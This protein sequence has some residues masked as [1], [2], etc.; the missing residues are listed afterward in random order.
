MNKPPL[1][2]A[3]LHH[4]CLDTS[5]INT[6]IPWYE[7]HL[8]IDSKKLSDGSVWLSGR[9]RNI[10][11]RPAAEKGL[12]Y[13]AYALAD[14]EQLSRFDADMTAKAVLRS[15]VHSPVFADGQFAII[16]PDGKCFVFGLPLRSKTDTP[17][18]LPGRLQHIG[19]CSTDINRL[20]NFFTNTVGF[21]ASDIVKNDDGKVS[22]CFLRSD[23]EHHDLARA[24]RL[25]LR[26]GA[27]VGGHGG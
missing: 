24:G 15:D 11:L 8:E 18:R 20:I 27:R 14:A 3:H 26:H 17:D 13:V 19:I 5:Q 21:R 10:V 23:H 7:T 6:L 25:A 12:A 1:W 4:F 2:P 16:D 9:Q 22:A